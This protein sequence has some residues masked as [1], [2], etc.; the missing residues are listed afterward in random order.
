MVIDFYKTTKKSIH[1]LLQVCSPGRFEDGKCLFCTIT[2]RRTLVLPCTTKGKRKLTTYG[3][4]PQHLQLMY[5]FKILKCYY[6]FAKNPTIIG[7]VELNKLGNV[8]LHFLFKDDS[9]TNITKLQ[10]FRRDIKN[11]KIV[12]DNMVDDTDHCNH[13]CVCDNVAETV[14]YLD[15]DYDINI[16]DDAPFY[17]YYL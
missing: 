14:K 5:C 7:T 1:D 3:S 16:K 10:I 12:E 13:I 2:P 15:K 9:I 4:L 17:N 11:C 6:E 8:H